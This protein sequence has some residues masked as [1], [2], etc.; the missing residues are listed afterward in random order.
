MMIISLAF[1]L[2]STV[3]GTAMLIGA[4]VAWIWHAKSPR[5]FGMFG[6]AIAAGCMAGEGI[7][8]VGNAALTIM[9]VDFDKAG[10]TFLCPAGKC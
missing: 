4:S 7:G 10:T 1:L 3:Y 5:T 6:T 2:P 8:G 9:G